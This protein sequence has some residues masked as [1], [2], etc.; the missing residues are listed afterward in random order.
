MQPRVV[1][2][3][4]VAALASLYIV[5]KLVTRRKAKQPI[6]QHLYPQITSH[7]KQHG[8][9]AP[10][11]DYAVLKSLHVKPQQVL[12]LI[13]DLVENVLLWND[14][15]QASAA[16]YTYLNSDLFAKHQHLTQVCCNA[17]V[18][19]WLVRKMVFVATQE[20]RAFVTDAVATRIVQFCA[21]CKETNK[22]P[23]EEMLKKR[24]VMD[25][26]FDPL[27]SFR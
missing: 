27:V 22:Q 24:Q 14:A 21:K 20:Q 9:I 25:L 6:L 18:C 4:C 12:D 11:D 19:A 1:V 17:Y 23:I 15:K 10:Q 2:V 16:M 13:H 3:S 8:K 26:I 5:Y 7:M